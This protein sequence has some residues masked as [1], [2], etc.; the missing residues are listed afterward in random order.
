MANDND[1]GKH[2]DDNLTAYVAVYDS[3]DAALADLKV[4]ENLHKED[5]VGTYDAAVVDRK[6]GTPHI[7]KRMD[8]PPIRIISEAFG[9]GPLKRKELK[10][11]ANELDA[12]QA[13]LIA[14][15]E[16][17]LDKAFDKAVTRAA[18][19]IKRV[20]DE[21][22]DELARDMKQAVQS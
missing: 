20:M 17:T 21:T 9:A 14:I 18:K 22:T 5:L 2:K 13:G 11:A 3:T 19:T 6:D 8:N 7:V 16:P 10:E 12:D 1:N 4:I 15:G